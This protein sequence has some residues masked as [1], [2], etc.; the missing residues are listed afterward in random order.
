MTRAVQPTTLPPAGARLLADLYADEYGSL[1]YRDPKV[2]T[3]GLT[4]LR[5]RNLA[6]VVGKTRWNDCRVELTDAGRAMAKEQGE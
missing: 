5:T 4:A 3:S 2:T 1:N 6:R